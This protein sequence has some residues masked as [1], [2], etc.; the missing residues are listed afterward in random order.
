MGRLIDFQKKVY[1][2]RGEDGMIDA[3]LSSIN[4]Q[5][6]WCC[7]FGAWDGIH[8]SNVY[9]RIREGWNAILI[10][11]D[12]KKFEHLSW[13]MRNYPG[14]H[15]HNS[16]VDLEE[17][18]LNTI[19]SHYPIPEDFDLLS[20]DIDSWDYWIW[21][22]LTYDPKIVVIEYNSN[23]SGRVTVPYDRT[24][25]FHYTQYFGAS[26]EALADLGEKKGYDLVAIV[27]YSNLIFLKSGLNRDWKP[28]DLRLGKHIQSPHHAPMT[29]EE[30][31]SLIYDPPY[32]WEDH[33]NTR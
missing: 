13:N 6:G 16:F 25:K 15:C 22:S 17:N 21:A 5:K 32:R 30:E 4:I 3:L 33:E 27:P 8:L 26:A 9:K 28:V 2:H 23:W 10:E 7:E 20:I 29:E 14:V 1:S 12:E 19:L 11:G 31:K 18:R 24:R